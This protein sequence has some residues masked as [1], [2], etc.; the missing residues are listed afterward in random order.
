MCRLQ[1]LTFKKQINVLSDLSV[2]LA[3]NAVIRFYQNTHKYMEQHRPLMK[4]LAFKLVV[5][6]VFLEQILFM[7]LDSTNVLHPTKY[8]SYAD[9]HIGLPTMIICVQLVPFAF[10]IHYAYSTK[11]YLVQEKLG[12]THHVGNSQEYLSVPPPESLNS[13]PGPR[14][15]QGGPLGLHAWAAYLNPLEIWSEVRDLYRIMYNIPLRTKKEASD[16]WSESVTGYEQQTAYNQPTAAVHAPLTAES[17]EQLHDEPL[18]ELDHQ[19]HEPMEFVQPGN[20][21]NTGYSGYPGLTVNEMENPYYDQIPHRNPDP[22]GYSTQY[23][24]GNQ[25]GASAHYSQ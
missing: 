11:P 22:Y 9:I 18:H 13:R 25:Y 3:I 15:Y 23:Q 8:M 21:S 24:G 14:S 16:P 4:L 12:F 1:V 19:P 7:I 2:S 5:G 17:T 20:S 6:L 10:F